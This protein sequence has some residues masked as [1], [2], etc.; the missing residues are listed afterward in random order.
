LSG[1][2]KTHLS[3]K[4]TDKSIGRFRINE[5]AE[6]KEGKEFTTLLQW[7]QTGREV[8]HHPIDAIGF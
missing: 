2:A 5:P 6:K 8:V 3:T 1:K 7:I 4:L